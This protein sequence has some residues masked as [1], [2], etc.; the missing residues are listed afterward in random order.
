MVQSLPCGS[1]RTVA[2]R[3]PS[4][5]CS[6]SAAGPR[7]PSKPSPPERAARSSPSCSRRHGLDR[8]RRAAR[9]RVAPQR[10]GRYFDAMQAVDRAARGGGREVHRRR[11]HGGVRHPAAARGR[12]DARRSRGRRDARGSRGAERASSSASAASRS[13]SAPASTPARSSPA[14][15]GRASGSSPATPS[16]SPPAWSSTREPGEIL[17]G[18]PTYRFVRDA[19]EVEPVEA[20]RAKGKA[21][22]VQ[23]YRLLEIAAGRR[24]PA[25]PPGLADGRPRTA[26]SQ[27]WSSALELLEERTA[28]SS[29]SSGPRAWGSPVWSPS[30]S[31][32]P[33]PGAT[34]LR[35]RCL[36][37]G[38]GI[39]Y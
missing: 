36:S 33:A 13:P 34:I 25:P 18:E 35:G 20:A 19:V 2:R 39:T 12:R 9:P 10:Q 32:G 3:T 14:T 37:Y 21:E 4:G 26:S 38:E 1:V 24:G 29:P 16:T 11:G 30:S 22:P 28:T 17:L 7:S 23:A 27:L 15:R 5:R 8:A 31:T 6:V